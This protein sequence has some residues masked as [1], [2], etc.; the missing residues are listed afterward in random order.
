MHPSPWSVSQISTGLIC[1]PLP[2]LSF[3]EKLEHSPES[4]SLMVPDQ[5]DSQSLTCMAHQ[6]P[7]SSHSSFS[8]SSCRW[9]PGTLSR[10][11]WRW[12]GKAGTDVGHCCG[13]LACSLCPSHSPHLLLLLWPRLGMVRPPG[14]RD[15]LERRPDM[16]GSWGIYWSSS[17]F[18]ES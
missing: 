17:C 2:A 6:P 18:A 5:V 14:L 15:Q 4:P 11:V 12:T 7:A 3:S 1:H 16:E 9:L 8:V 13:R 10:L